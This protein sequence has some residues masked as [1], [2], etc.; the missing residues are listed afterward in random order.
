MLNPERVE[1]VR[2]RLGLTKVGFADLLKID[3]RTL[4]RF[5][6]SSD[7]PLPEAAVSTLCEV[8]GYPREFFALGRVEFPSS[9]AVSFR[10]QRSLTAKMRDAALAVSSLAFEFDDWITDQYDLPD[11]AVEATRDMSPENAAM[12]VRVQWGIGLRPIGNMINLLESKGVRVFSLSE[13]TRHLDA[14]SFWRN[15]R[16]YVFLNTLKTSERSRFDA[17]HELG[18]LVMHQHTGSSHPN[19]EREAD[20]FASA[21]LMPRD[22]LLSEVLWINS[23][24]D[25]VRY[26]KR[27]GVSASALAY[28]LHKMGRISDWHYR[29]YCIEL[30]K[31]GRDFEPDAMP[32]ETSLIWS[33]VLTDLWRRGV[34]L[35]R[36][37][38]MLFVPEKE[39]SNLLFG[40]TSEPRQ[41]PDAHRPKKISVC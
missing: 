8:S 11:N 34:P 30:G 20:A 23:L 10:S 18:H 28:S 22:D 27:W 14:Y 15:E 29:G 21:F 24:H 19:A 4:S 40:I 3:R 33:K 5:Y 12:Y 38:Q 26:K 32:R 6:A 13:E 17:A 35:S 39:L 9:E 36:I 25:L 41:K 1:L 16:A 37:A 31:L 7:S 2:M